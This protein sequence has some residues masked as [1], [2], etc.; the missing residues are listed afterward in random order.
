MSDDSNKTPNGEP[1]A[2]ASGDGKGGNRVFSQSEHDRAIAEAVKKAAE[3]FKDFDTVKA[4]LDALEKE[5]AEKELSEKSEL[6]KR[7]IKISELQKTI[8]SEASKAKELQR[9]MVLQN[10]LSREEYRGLPDVYKSTV[11]PSDDEAEVDKSAKA[12]LDKFKKDFEQTTGKKFGEPKPEQKQNTSAPITS[13][14]GL[15]QRMRAA[16]LGK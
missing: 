12:I 15:A 10:V 3:Q 7:D 8:E 13:P 11:T 6:E 4:K 9:K 2:P 16:I 5:K 14:E 1:P